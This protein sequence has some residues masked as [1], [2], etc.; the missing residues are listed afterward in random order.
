MVMTVMMMM[1]TMILRRNFV[2]LFLDTMK[3]FDKGKIVP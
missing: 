2:F 1:M 3:S